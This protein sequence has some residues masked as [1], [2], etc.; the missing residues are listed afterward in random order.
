[1]VVAADIVA[2]KWDNSTAVVVVVGVAVVGIVAF[3]HIGAGIVSVEASAVIV[4]AVVADSASNFL[5]G[6]CA[7]A[8]AGDAAGIGDGFVVGGAVSFVAVALVAHQIAVVVVRFVSGHLVLVVARRFVRAVDTSSGP[9]VFVRFVC[10][11]A[12]DYLVGFVFV[13]AVVSVVDLAGFVVSVR[14]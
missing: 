10:V 3:E 14:A 6:S 7:G 1:M 12:G 5:R 9:A 13:G 11:V 4:G 8:S 2:D